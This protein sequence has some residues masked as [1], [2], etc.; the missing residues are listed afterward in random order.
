MTSLRLLHIEDSPFETKIL[1]TALKK[2]GYTVEILRVQT[3]EE[4]RRAIE[5]KTFDIVV[6]DYHLPD[7]DGSQAL[8]L[9]NQFHLDIP[10][11]ILSGKIGEELAV[12]L[13]KK[14]AHDYILKGKP[15][16]L[17]P[18]IETQL[19]AF[20]DRR[21]RKE[22]SLQLERSRNRYHG[23]FQR[24]PLGV[25]RLDEDGEFKEVNPA[26]AGI[27]GFQEGSGVLSRRM[28]WKDCQHPD[29][30]PSWE[31]LTQLWETG[32]VFH[33]DSLWKDKDGNLLEVSLHLW[34][35]EESG[36]KFLDGLVEDLRE[37]RKL[38][39]RLKKAEELDQDILD[40]ATR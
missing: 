27:L 40:F 28:H 30:S 20:Q 36:E 34:P 32:K 13:I 39:R 22:A 23:L 4:M 31:S 35:V 15:A 33:A 12:E 29:H 2:N 10:F 3:S 7:F 9:F 26:F 38:E 1:E 18:A 25:F 5:E 24:S 11:I 21:G 6:S 8:V 37:K 14:G 16:R 17:V 19:K